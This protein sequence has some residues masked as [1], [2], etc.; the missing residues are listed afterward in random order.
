MKHI[1]IQFIIL[2][3]S[4]LSGVTMS[5]AAPHITRLP[6]NSL[7]NYISALS[8]DSEGLIWIG[9]GAGLLKYDGYSYY[10][11]R[12]DDR[13]PLAGSHIR[14]FLPEADGTLW[15]GTENGA[16]TCSSGVFTLVGG[17]LEGKPVKSIVKS[18]NGMIL[19]AGN[20]GIQ[21][22]DPG[23]GK[24]IFLAAEGGKPYYRNRRWIVPDS[25]GFLWTGLRNKI[26]RFKFEGDSMTPQV[27]LLKTEGSVKV[28][29]VDE[30]GGMYYLAD[31]DD[32]FYCVISADGEGTALGE[33]VKLISKADVRGVA[34]FADE[35]R[36]VTSYN[37]IYCFTISPSGTPQPSGHF[38]IN[39]NDHADISNGVLCTIADSKG[40]FLYGTAD[41]LYAEWN[42][43]ESNFHNISGDG[44]GH[45]LHN[46]VSDLYTADGSTV[47]VTTNR[48]L[49]QLEYSGGSVISVR[50]HLVPQ[51]IA[52]NTQDYSLQCICEDDGKFWLGN[53][54]GILVF[55]PATSRFSNPA[56]LLSGL[57]S[58]GAS[59][60]KT[61]TKSADG[62]LWLGFIYGGLFC[63]NS[64]RCY[65]VSLENGDITSSNVYKIMDDSRG[66]I[67]VGTKNKGLV[68]FSQSDVRI[69][70]DRMYV[71]DYQLF[72]NNE[73]LSVFDIFE[74]RD[75]NVFAAT[76]SGLY[77]VSGADG[78]GAV[79]LSD[80]RLFCNN[81]IQDTYG[82][83][84]ISSQSGI[85]WMDLSFSGLR[86]YETGEASFS[87][88]DYNT[89]SCLAHDGTVLF[90]GVNGVTYFNPEDI[91][92]R[93]D[94][95]TVHITNMTVMGKPAALTPGGELYLKP[96]DRHFSISLSTLDFP[97]DLLQN[98][99]Y[100]VRESGDVWIP[101]Q[102]N[103]ISFANLAPGNYNIILS[104]TESGEGSTSLQVSIAAP[105]WRRWWAYCLYFIVF[106]LV[107]GGTIFLVLSKIRSDDQ[108]RTF[109]NIT[110]GLKTPLSLMKVP[111]VL[112]KNGEESRKGDLLDL[113]DRNA[114]KLADTLNQILEL[115]KV[116]RNRAH[117]FIWRIDA[118]EFLSKIGNYFEP[119]FREKGINLIQ[120]YPSQPCPVYCDPEKLEMIV[121]NLLQNAFSFTPA[122]GE[123]TLS[124][125]S[126]GRTITIG[127]SDTGIGIDRKFH[128][129]IFER[130]W[131][132]RENGV[133][134]SRGSGIGLSL[135]KEYARMHGGKVTVESALGLGAEFKV[136]LPRNRFRAMAPEKMEKIE[137]NY[138]K[139]YAGNLPVSG[140][141][142]VEASEG[143]KLVFVVSDSSDMVTML[144]SIFGGYGIL[145]T[146]DYSSAFQVVQDKSP[147]IIL[148][149]VSES[150]VEKALGLCRKIK[151]EYE[152][153]DIPVVFLTN[154]DSPV[155]AKL[156]YE[157]GA[158]SHIAKPFDP[159]L[160]RV[161]AEKLIDKHLNI[162][163][164]IKVEKLISS[165]V[166]MDVE[167]ADQRFL[168]DMMEIIE[169]NIPSENFTLDV[170]AREAHISKS[171][172][173]SRLRSITGR[174]P[175]ELVR[176]ARMQRASQL[177]A[178]KAYDV[179]QVSYMVGFSDPRYFATCFKKYFN[180]TP[181]NYMNNI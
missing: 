69:N 129:K 174:S 146:D 108:M 32:L 128:K 155:V 81:I 111:V 157:N 178:T 166:E 156:C 41:G 2:V 115:R 160:L 136:I 54:S 20:D 16:M 132:Y 114:D 47:W 119:Y 39:D 62:S 96:A 164:R 168:K 59:F 171:I 122:G 28:L 124:L 64:G 169:N 70:G 49:D 36:V 142:A 6:F 43:S 135:V 101:V 23:K 95:R 148:V 138:T 126:E 175:M 13:T 4:L 104:C 38:W 79:L 107:L 85:Y 10:D 120:S 75:S 163:E 141:S 145:S 48:G 52:G 42:S 72:L 130:F 3:S 167:T 112:L 1:Y 78:Y 113:V 179:T 55:N 88:L 109:F 82:N 172:L 71:L 170:F 121:F 161:R 33:R 15:I 51:D 162:R 25:G 67:W 137:P 118:C 134:P 181:S 173:G 50:H 17:E 5:A 80:R 127:V 123:V 125:L 139:R 44:V 7:S 84:W 149:D 66:N 116:D 35:V 180:C 176:N 105:W 165:D 21:V 89:G 91:S 102:G 87:L 133:I 68:R 9:T 97:V 99:Y 103:T 140:S 76:S 151:S 154:D 117:L 31:N 74:D 56:S 106:S 34:C 46:V 100:K 94:A 73:Q 131:Q 152:F 24:S 58:E 150:S 22:L 18:P 40:S 143:S 26:A 27:S 159:E 93:N 92:F 45:L 14:C 144:S 19:L 110:H 37:G 29:Y 8:Q 12:D 90:G 83:Y 65:K 153:R 57:N 61:I 147:D 77:L 63:V 98:Y 177:L 53:K 11:F 86:F 60:C 158:D 30:R